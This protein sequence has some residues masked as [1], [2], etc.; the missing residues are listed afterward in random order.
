MLGA[1]VWQQF[2]GRAR[3]HSPSSPSPWRLA[4]NSPR[5]TSTGALRRIGEFYA[6]NAAAIEG[7]RVHTLEFDSGRESKWKYTRAKLIDMVFFTAARLGR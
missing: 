6:E 1:T 5:V 7:R 2:G 3:S 4:N